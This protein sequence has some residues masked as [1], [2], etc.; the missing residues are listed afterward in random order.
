MTR[1]VSST[2][3][4]AEAGGPSS[5]GVGGFLGSD[6][7]SREEGFDVVSISMNVQRKRK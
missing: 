5:V 7:S 3:P 6:S 1:V 4:G 2:S